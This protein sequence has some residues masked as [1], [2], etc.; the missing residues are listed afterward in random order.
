MPALETQNISKNFDGVQAVGGVD[1]A[2]EAGKITGLIGPNGS[3]KTTLINLLTGIFPFD[4]GAVLISDTVK[5]DKI[6]RP[7]VAGYGMTRT[8]QQVRLFEQ[9]TVLDNILVATTERN[10]F[11]SLFERHGDFHLDKAKDVLTRVGLWE[12]RDELAANLS[13]GQRKLLEIARVMVMPSQVIFFDEPYAGLFPEMVKLVSDIV[14]ELKVSGRTIVLVEH[15]MH[16]IRELCD[17]LYVMDSGQVLA[18]GKPEEVLADRKVVE[19]NL[20]E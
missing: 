9:I 3:G 6:D 16:L 14:R 8:F 15:N 1:I 2:F 4:K 11:S 12:K 10:V 20:G 7:E 19:A 5:L 18:H 13:Y 17:Y